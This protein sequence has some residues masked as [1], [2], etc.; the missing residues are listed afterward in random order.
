M[1]QLLIVFRDGRRLVP[2]DVFSWML[3]DGVLTLEYKTMYVHYPLDT[4]DR[5]TVEKRN[6]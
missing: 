4:I 6:T 5:F 1:V 2:N 3:E